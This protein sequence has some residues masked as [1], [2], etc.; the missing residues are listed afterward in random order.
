MSEVINMLDWKKRRAARL[1]ATIER[2]AD[3]VDENGNYLASAEPIFS[4]VQTDELCGEWLTYRLT[5]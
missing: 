1:A 5:D 4:L 3:L 2:N